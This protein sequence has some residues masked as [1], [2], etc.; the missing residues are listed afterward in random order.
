ML[1]KHKKT[2]KEFTVSL[3][4]WNKIKAKGNSD[5]YKILAAPET[6]KEKKNV[7]TKQAESDHTNGFTNTTDRLPGE[8]VGKVE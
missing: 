8:D 4:Q 2:G 7:R 1:I 3:E 5:T 6:P